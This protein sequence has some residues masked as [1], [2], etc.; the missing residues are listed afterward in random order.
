MNAT[1]V[2]IAKKRVNANAEIRIG[3]ALEGDA[4]TMPTKQVLFFDRPGRREDVW[5]ERLM[6]IFKAE[7]F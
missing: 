4:C 5:V 1:N 6:I 7:F 2:E 3:L